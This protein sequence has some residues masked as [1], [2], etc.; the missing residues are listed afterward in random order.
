MS[1][2]LRLIPRKLREKVLDQKNHSLLQSCGQ[3]QFSC[4]YDKPKDSL[5]NSL[6]DKYGSDKGEIKGSGH[7]YPW[8]SHSYADFY[9]RLFGHCRSEIKSVFECGL[10]TNNQDIPSNMTTNGKPGASLRVWRDYFPNARIYGADIDR[11]ILFF[12]ER[13]KTFYCDQTDPT[14][15][16]EL[17]DEMEAVRFCLMIDDG[18]HTFDAGTIL[19]E[20]SFRMLRDGGVYVIEDVNVNDTHKFRNYFRSRGLC[21]DIVSFKS[22]NNIPFGEWSIVMIRK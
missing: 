15:V 21:C 12:D 3:S 22:G 20:N 16:A 2:L 9:E 17:W 19:F 10:G 11:N 8:S 7:P 5:L 14:S 1:R 4:F 13:I 6:C 18:L